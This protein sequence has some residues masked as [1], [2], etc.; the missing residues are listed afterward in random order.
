MSKSRE[1]DAQV[2]EAKASRFRAAHQLGQTRSIDFEVLLRRLNVLTVFRPLDS[3]FSGMALKSGENRFILVNSDHSKGKQNFTI[4]HELYHLFIQERFESQVCNTGRFNQQTD[5]EERNAD[6]FAAYLLM[7]YDS[8][9]ARIPEEEYEPHPHLSLPTIVKLEQYLQCSRAALL[10]RLKAMKLITVTEE[11]EFK[12]QVAESA[13]R[14]GYSADLY[15]ATPNRTPIGDYAEL[16]YRLY[17][18]EL[19]SE[20]NYA[21]LL[22]D[23]GLPLNAL[24]SASPE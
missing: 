4:A 22:L 23:L 7:P 20:T 13:Q 14:L 10:V 24:H 21:G 15:R 3:A 9:L 17:D 19:I 12:Q 18:R 2:I 1:L 5:A 16:A 11:E 8:I 6:W